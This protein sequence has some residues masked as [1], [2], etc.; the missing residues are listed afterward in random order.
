M[1]SAGAMSGLAVLDLPLLVSFHF[2]GDKE[3]TSLN[4]SSDD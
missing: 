1:D 4:S 2:N 3:A